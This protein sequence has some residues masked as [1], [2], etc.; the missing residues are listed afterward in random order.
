MLQKVLA[1]TP[2]AWAHYS[3][4]G[5][6]RHPEW[7]QSRIDFQPYPYPSYTEKLVEMLKQTHIAGVNRFLDALDPAQVAQDL[8][9]DRFVKQA[10]IQGS[11]QAVFKLNGW[12]RTETIVV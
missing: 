10:V 5:I 7:Q 3:A 6:I 8:V 1:P 4:S 2:D 9:D 12:T 11:H